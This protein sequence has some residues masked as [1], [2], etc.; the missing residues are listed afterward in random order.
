VTPA[1][2][3]PTRA[4]SFVCGPARHGRAAGESH[5]PDAG[6]ITAVVDQET[7]CSAFDGGTRWHP[8]SPAA[9]VS[10]CG[11]ER[12]GSARLRLGRPTL[13]RG[14]GRRPADRAL[15]SMTTKV[16]KGVSLRRMIAA[17]SVWTC[18]HRTQRVVAGVLGIAVLGVLAGPAIGSTDPGHLGSRAAGTRASTGPR[19]YVDPRSDAAIQEAAWLHSDPAAAAQ[20]AKI[21][22]QPMA[23]WLGGSSDEV[24]AAVRRRVVAAAAAGSEAQF[25][26]YNVPQRDC[27]GYSSGGASSASA[28]RAWIRAFAA[29]IGSR[30]AIVILEPDALASMNCLSV[31]D[32]GTRLSLLRDGVSVLARHAGI[33]LYIDAGHAG[34]H[35]PAAM[36]ERLRHAGIARAQGFALNVA[37][38]DA[39]KSEVKYGRSISALVGGKH[40]VID[41][42]RNGNGSDG[43]WCNAPGR[44]LGV[45]PTAATGFPLVDAF[46]WIKTP[47]VSDG[48]CNGG[49]PAGTW[50]PSY[51]LAL[52]ENASSR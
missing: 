5:C 25:V 39:T 42:S 33:R 15:T 12:T 24:F 36:A 1:R 27:G 16:S 46:L 4:H 28:Y 8:R 17:A 11:G 52:A 22:A 50:W 40:F 3:H 9:R 7:A 32:R 49:P 18:R 41:T 51:A 23:E 43:Q 6:E 26:A 13:K 20:I 48:T 10:R 19:W 14:E 2:P 21:A 35:T 31:P 47:G 45:P 38:Y 30:G 37:G 34:W 44:A 29:G